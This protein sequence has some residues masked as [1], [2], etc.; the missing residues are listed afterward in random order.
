MFDAVIFDCDGCLVDSEVLVAEVE[1]DRLAAIGLTYE[2]DDYFARFTGLSMAAFYETIAAES[3]A[4]LG[5]PLPE[6]FAAECQAAVREAADLLSQAQALAGGTVT[7]P[8]TTSPPATTPPTTAP[9]AIPA[10]ANGPILRALI[11]A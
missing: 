10:R 8:D 2:R 1:F 5:R 9:Q 6:T 7:T 11:G 4:R 3:V